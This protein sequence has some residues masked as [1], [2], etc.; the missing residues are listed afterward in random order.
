MYW[1]V[2]PK[3]WLQQVNSQKDL[4]FRKNLDQSIPTSLLQERSSDAGPTKFSSEI[5]KVKLK[6]L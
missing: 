5:G 1:I 3:E 4:T 6:N 2:F